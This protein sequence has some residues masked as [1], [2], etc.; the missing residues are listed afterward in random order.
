MSQPQPIYLQD[1]TPPSHW[2]DQVD[3]HFDLGA[4]HTDVHAKLAV[5][6]NTARNDPD[7]VLN[8]QHLELLAVQLDG[9]PLSRDQYHCDE[10]Q[11]R[12][13]ALPEQFTLDI[14]T[15]L[16]PQD[17]T[18]L[19]GLYQSSGNFCT[20]CEAQGFRRITYFLD[21]PDVMA[22]YTTTLVADQQRYP[23]LLSNGNPVAQGQHPDG[24]HWVTWHDPHPKPSYLFALMAGDLAYLEDHYTTCSGRAVN[25]R[26]YT[27]A[28]HVEQ[29]YHAMESLKKAMHWDEQAF[30]CE[31]DLDVYN[32]VAVSDFN[33]GAMENKG[34]N[35]FNT[36]YVLAH[37]QTATDD[38][39]QHVESVIAHEYF[40][41]WTGNRVTC[42]DWFQLSLKEGL[43]VF[44]DQQFS[45]DQGSRGVKRIEDVNILRSVQFPQDAGPMAH[46]VR[47]YS[48]IEIN[49]FYTVTVYNKGAEVIR[50]L[51]QLL[52]QAGFRRGMDSYFHRHDGQAVT[53]DDFVTAM[54]DANGVDL[55]Q[56]RL[57]YSQV[58][59]PELYIS[60]HYDA[61]N[62]RYTLTVRQHIPGRGHKPPLHIP[63]AVGLLDPQ[64]QDLPLQLVAEE[65]PAT[66]GTRVLAL[67]QLEQQFCFVHIPQRPVPSL[68]RE[69]SAPVHLHYD[70]SDAELRFLLAHDSDDFNR[71]EA[72]QRL[73][74]RTMMTL[75]QARQAGQTFTLPPPLLETLG[76]VLS[77]ESI[78]PALCALI[79]TLPSETY[80]AEQM[81]PVDV[82]GIHAVRTELKHAVATA[83]GEALHSRYHSL[84]GLSSACNTPHAMGQRRLKNVCLSYLATQVEGRQSALK[85]YQQA[86]TMTD[87]LAALQALTYS[88]SDEREAVLADFFTRWAHEPLVVDKWFRLQA[89][90]P[91][92][93]VLQQIQPLL[94]HPAFEIRNPNKV[95][96]LIGAFSHNPCG[97]HAADGSGYAFVAENI[98]ALDT[99]NP[100]V[101]A[102]LLGAYTRWRKYDADRQHYMR[103][104]LQR[105]LAKPNVSPDV[106]E[107]AAKSL[108][109]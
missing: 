81:Q 39:Y 58:G 73:I 94:D 27:E 93:D 26:I 77:A 53:C 49:N 66:H 65:R 75:I 88:D 98:I 31:Y 11:L 24:R 7:L 83:L 89:S 21:R 109:G 61:E 55:D 107:I 70:Y 41:N 33:M 46:P 72:S 95:Y 85:Q 43:T 96:A 52:G 28:H 82:D 63:L 12:F 71:W 86:T 92:M 6:R 23:V 68:L 13:Q 50:M 44:R 17:N 84:S 64:G 99:L 20:Q 90:A 56:F 79:L 102:R 1:Y 38:D 22:V 16:Y 2:I 76:Q 54:E 35:I 42:R 19:E 37:P 25:L 51:Y 59:T 78:D 60:D 40:H 80:L 30:G 105:I 91:R 32:I 9:T 97:F 74:I 104:A 8:G 4:T 45:A 34:L 100:Q 87:Q 36:K 3:L 62:Q 47:P 48:Y 15:R 10:Q 18:A 14:T 69:F 106:Y 67:R 29:C 5:R 101:A 57:W 108:G 103:T